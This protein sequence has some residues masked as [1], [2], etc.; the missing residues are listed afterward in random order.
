MTD[1]SKEFDDDIF[2]KYDQKRHEI[3][4]DPYSLSKQSRV[5]IE[6]N[7][8]GDVQNH[9][10]GSVDH[11]EKVQMHSHRHIHKSSRHQTKNHI[12]EQKRVIRTRYSIVVQSKTD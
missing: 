4:F 11:A 1:D 7:D 10:T 9:M 6:Q 3:T 2:K 8:G 5:T 12:K